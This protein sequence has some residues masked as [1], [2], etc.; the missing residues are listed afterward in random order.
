MDGFPEVTQLRCQSAHTTPLRAAAAAAV[1][2]AELFSSNV[3]VLLFF[4]LLTGH[5][6]LKRRGYIPRT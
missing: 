1:V 3:A 5:R 2:A 6:V 4:R